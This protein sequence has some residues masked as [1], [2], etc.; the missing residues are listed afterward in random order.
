MLLQSNLRC[1]D[2]LWEAK[3]REGEGNLSLCFSLSFAANVASYRSCVTIFLVWMKSL[4]I[5]LWRTNWRCPSSPLALFSFW[6]GNVK[7]SSL[8]RT[9]RVPKTL[10]ADLDHITHSRHSSITLFFSGI[11]GG[12]ARLAS[13]KHCP[14]GVS[15]TERRFQKKK[16]QNQ[17]F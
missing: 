6:G 2:R 15:L 13:G 14:W 9:L 12:C 5:N 3:P 11:I 16:N 1:W 10:P 7:S 4:L 8:E 17:I